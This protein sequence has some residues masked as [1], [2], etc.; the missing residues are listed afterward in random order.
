VTWLKGYL[1]GDN[2]TVVA[3]NG[4]EVVEIVTLKS[5]LKD[6]LIDLL[7]QYPKAK[8]FHIA[9]PGSE[10]PEGDRV[11]FA[12]RTQTP[13]KVEN[14]PTLDRDLL[15]KGMSDEDAPGHDIREMQKRLKD[16]GYYSKEIDGIFGSG[17][18]AAVR[19]FQA[20]VFSHA[21]AD[22]KVGPKTWA[23]LWGE[24]IVDRNGEVAP[25]T[26]LRLTKTNRKDTYGC[27][28]LLLQYIKSGKVEGS[29]EV[30]S[31][32]PSKQDFRIGRKSKSGS[33][34][35]L[36]E[37]KWYVCD[38]LWAGGKDK[39]GPTVHNNGLGPVTTP[40][41]YKGPDTT[42]RR[43]IEIHIDW[44]GHYR[45]GR[46]APGTAGCVGIYNVAD[47]KTFVRWLRDT[48]PRDLYVDWGL[49]TCPKP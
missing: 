18:D 3:Y 6:D 24:K 29:L 27:Y 48:D 39:Y 16:L 42:E 21:E 43:G 25:G 47:Y 40:I 5:N 32:Q 45:G 30:C 33:M 11:E 1:E 15:L 12:G 41:Q 8:N 31:G 22:G 34:E 7:Q 13:S 36:P 9:P 17:T 28:V 26:Y 14:P 2:T 10:I 38:I 49:G 44:N 4:S 23:K 19:E 46:P 35:P 20:D 37:G